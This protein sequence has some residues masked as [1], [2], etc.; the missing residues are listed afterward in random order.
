VFIVTVTPFFRVYLCYIF[1]SVILLS[2]L[3]MLYSD[4][5][6]ITVHDEVRRLWKEVVAYFKVLS[7]HFLERFRIPYQTSLRKASV[8]AKN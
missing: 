8:R 4:K 3:L 6:G 5:W 1:V 7:L 2:Q